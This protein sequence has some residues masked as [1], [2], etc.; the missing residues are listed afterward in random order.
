MLFWGILGV[1][2][3]RAIMIGLGATLVTQFSWILCVFGVFLVV[4]GVKMWLVADHTPDIANNMVLKFLR[5]CMRQVTLAADATKG[6]QTGSPFHLEL[7]S[8]SGIWLCSGRSAFAHQAVQ[9]C[10]PIGIGQQ[11]GHG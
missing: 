4:T 7:S 11:V 10:V 9:P 3:L 8:S 6:C 5:K 2:V 1:I